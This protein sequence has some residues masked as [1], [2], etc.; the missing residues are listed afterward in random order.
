MMNKKQTSKLGIFKYTL[1]IPVI[2]ALVVFNSACKP[3]TETAQTV[4]AVEITD[5]AETAVALDTLSQTEKKVYSHVE[6]MPSFPGGEKA[7]MHFLQENI[8]YP[9]AAAEQGIEGRVIVRFVVTEDGS[10]TDVEVLRSLDPSCDE[11][12]I[13][14]VK[15]M[16][17]WIPGKQNG[18][19]VAVYYT[20]PILFRLQK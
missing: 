16:P 4:E 2:G 9:V 11:E 7:L 18:Q 3:R 17:N 15:K 12:A 14:V 5:I 20:L 13:S 1:L 19:A 8:A 6:V 10:V